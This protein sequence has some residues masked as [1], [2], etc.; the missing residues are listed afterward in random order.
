MIYNIIHKKT[1]FLVYRIQFF[2]KEI[3]EALMKKL[4]KNKQFDVVKFEKKSQ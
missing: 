2:D 3:C 4:K 1:G